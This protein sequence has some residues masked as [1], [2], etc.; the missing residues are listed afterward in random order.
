LEANREKSDTGIFWFLSA[1]ASLAGVDYKDEFEIPVFRTKDSPAATSGPAFASFEAPAS[2]ATVTSSELA[3]VGITVVPSPKGTE[4]HFAAAR[5]KSA[6][7]G[8]TGFAVLWA[9]C[10][11]F[12]HSVHAPV[13][14]PVVF[15]L[16]EALFVLIA[17][18]L[19]FGST[20][21][22]IGNGALHKQYFLL[23]IPSARRSMPASDV[24]KLRL[25]VGM[26]SGGRAGVPYY[27]I[28]ALLVNGREQ[29]LA[30]SIRDKHQAEWLA[31]QMS[32]ALGLKSP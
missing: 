24:S 26:Q 6:S 28:R 15:G 11:W 18:D 30:G 9:G 8:L 2:F 25:K 21:I 19:W 10:L 13:I 12:L 23:G 20:R 1:E 16:F 14:F 29:T 17:M 31:T 3:N 7:A 32:A 27:D 22:T 4:F 5:N